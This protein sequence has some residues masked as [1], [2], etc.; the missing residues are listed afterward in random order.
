MKVLQRV[1]FESIHDCLNKD[2]HRHETRVA[3]TLRI[4][5]G[6]LPSDVRSGYGLSDEALQTAFYKGGMYHDIGKIVFDQK[7]FK[8]RRSAAC[9]TIHNHLNQ[10][11][12]VGLD[13]LS[14]YK[15]GIFESEAER[16]ICGD[17]TVYHHERFDGKGYPFE[18]SHKKIPFAAQLCAL[19][20]TFDN[21]VMQSPLL[22]GVNHAFETAYKKTMSDT[23]LAEQTA[24]DCIVAAREKIKEK[25]C[26]KKS[27][28][29]N[30][31]MLDTHRRVSEAQ[32]S[33]SRQFEA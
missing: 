4:L 18:Y 22:L 7:L 29:R 25:Y 11:P 3:E 21:H 6:F 24:M 26:S 13:F 32:F 20:D 27:V 9:Q 5:A 12:I 8:T 28:F 10:H 1:Q 31:R 17:I 33:I 15:H 16:R 2:I 19:A 23:G 30:K 14:E